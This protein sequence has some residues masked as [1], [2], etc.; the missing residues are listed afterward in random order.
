MQLVD[1]ATTEY[2]KARIG[3]NDV[4]S[5]YTFI[6]GALMSQ[7]ESS[8]EQIVTNY[9]EYMFS[10]REEW[11]GENYLKD[12]DKLRIVQ[13]IK[14]NTGKSYVKN[15]AFEALMGINIQL[16]KNTDDR[17]LYAALFLGLVIRYK[18]GKD[19]IVRELNNLHLTANNF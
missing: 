19:Y 1:I 11:Y 2:L 8:I 6:N 9:L 7:G 10:A 3:V 16:V 12:M 18:M 15:E 14:Y 17:C 13:V 4:K 5:I